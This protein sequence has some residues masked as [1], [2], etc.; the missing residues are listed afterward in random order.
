MP[1]NSRIDSVLDDPGTL[2]IARVYSDAFLNAAGD[3]AAERIEEF[4]SFLEDV[5][6]ANPQFE[7]ML[8]T[9]LS[10]RDEKLGFIDRVVAPHSSEFFANYLRVL[11]QHDRLGILKEVLATARLEYE[12]RNGQQ[13]VQVVSVK[14]LDQATL[15]R[16]KERVAEAFGFEPIIEPQTDS[17]LIGGIVIRVGNSVY[18]GSLRSWLKQLAK[19][20][21]QGS[22]HEIQ[23]GRDRFSHPEGD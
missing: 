2:A 20:M 1:E 15:A 12:K 19:K 5:L 13:R 22:L 6:A 3:N 16:V 9:S 17:S 18:D 4:I 7:S 14:P 21:H 10:N 23:S 11:A 8:I